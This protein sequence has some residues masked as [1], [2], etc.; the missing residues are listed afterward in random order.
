MQW[1]VSHPS[2]LASSHEMRGQRCQCIMLS[3][4]YTPVIPGRG[5]MVVFKATGPDQFPD[6]KLFQQF[7]LSL[8]KLTQCAHTTHINQ[9]N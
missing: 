3:L 7:Y 5:V 2:A 8:R 4:A 6:I 1:M 9:A